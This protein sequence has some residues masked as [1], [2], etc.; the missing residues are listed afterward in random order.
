MFSMD[1]EANVGFLLHDASRLMRAW[2]DE[3]AQ[4]LGLTRAQWRVLVHLGPREGINQASLAE[5]LELDTVTLSR[6]LDRLEKS[7]WVER[8][9]DPEDRRAWQIHLGEPSRPVLAQMQTLAVET[10]VQ[11]LAGLSVDDCQRLVEVLTRIKA[12]MS[13]SGQDADDAELRERM[14]G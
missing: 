6:H 8:R 4:A 1:P 10:Q 2:F 5:I 12:N 3:R 7:G 9:R 14:T 13:Q 11:A